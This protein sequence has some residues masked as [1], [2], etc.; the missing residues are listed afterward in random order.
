MRLVNCG[1]HVRHV[2]LVWSSCIF[3]QYRVV[4]S[5]IRNICQFILCFLDHDLI[6]H[7]RQHFNINPQTPFEKF[8]SCFLGQLPDS[9]QSLL[10]EGWLSSFG[11]SV[12]EYNIRILPSSPPMYIG[13][14]NSTI[15]PK[16]IASLVQSK[17]VSTFFS[18]I[19]CMMVLIFLTM[20]SW[21]GTSPEHTA[22]L[23]SNP[24]S[25]WIISLIWLWT[26]GRIG[27]LG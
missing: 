21:L 25:S 7:F 18:L 3:W 8:Q 1:F 5:E 11:S 12:Q 10:R 27:S 20:S 15:T 14:A 9:I 4:F 17:S 23:Q 26:R 19:L 24:K 2:Q 16:A 22:H 13:F 6:H